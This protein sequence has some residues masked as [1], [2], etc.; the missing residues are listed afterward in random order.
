MLLAATVVALVWVNSPFGDSYEHLWEE[1]VDIRA[2]SFHLEM[3]L[4]QVVNDGLMAIFFF[5]VGLEIKRELVTGELRDARAAAMPALA[6]V[7][8]MVVPALIYLASTVGTDASEGWGIPMATDIA[9]AL[10]VVALLGSRVPATLKIFLLTLAI[11]DDIGGILVI[12]FFYTSEVAF[13]WLLAAAGGLVLVVVM[14]RLQVSWTPIYVAVGA[15]VWF[16]TH[17]SGVH[18]TI[19]GVALGLLTPARPLLTGDE[20][21]AVT[22]GEHP[23]AEDVKLAS[24][25]LRERVSVVERL[26]AALHPYSA[27]FIV[28]VFALSNAGIS[29]SGSAITEA[30]TASITIGV[31]LG[32]VVGKTVGVVT[33]AWL[34]TRIGLPLPRGAS[35]SQVFGIAVASGIGFTVALFIDGLAFA[36]DDPLLEQAKMGI[37]AASLVA[38]IGALVVLRWAGSTPTGQVES[39]REPARDGRTPEPVAGG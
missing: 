9:F 35:W 34:G 5:V 30:S 29:L 33:F 1:V 3:T 16:A 26:E 15:F 17:E 21:S 19:A 31:F 39:L 7:G 6:A 8:G 18:A 13:T 28:P 36:P 2:G 24:M 38:A 27:F 37:F 32:L 20:P 12:A 11:V 14:Q 4:H 22:I 25:E 10:G 23:T